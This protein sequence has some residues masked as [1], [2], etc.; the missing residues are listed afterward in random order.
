MYRL[1]R[2]EV[3]LTREGSGRKIEKKVTVKQVLI[4][5]LSREDAET[6]VM[7]SEQYRFWRD[8]GGVESVWVEPEPESDVYDYGTCHRRPVD[9]HTWR[10]LRKQDESVHGK[11]NDAG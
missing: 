11:R 9:Q 7:M 4:V 1:W 5:A 8:T 10:E 2:A 6:K 3:E